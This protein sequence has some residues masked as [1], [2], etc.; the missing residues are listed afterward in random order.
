MSKKNI[1]T[2]RTGRTKNI[3]RRLFDCSVTATDWDP[4]T[5][6][7]SCSAF[8]MNDRNEDK[9][10][11]RLREETNMHMKETSVTKQHKHAPLRIRHPTPAVWP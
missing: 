9:T 7:Q 11:L 4:Q 5:H 10:G 6:S 8:P 1:A 2:M 3:L